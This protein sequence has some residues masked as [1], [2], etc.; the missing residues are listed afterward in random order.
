MVHEWRQQSGLSIR[1]PTVILIQN[2]GCL[3]SRDLLR[4]A[5]LYR[6]QIG[7]PLAE[8][9][10]VWSSGGVRFSSVR[11]VSF[12]FRFWEVSGSSTDCCDWDSSLFSQ[13][14]PV[15]MRMSR[16]TK[17][18]SR[19]LPLVYQFVFSLITAQSGVKRGVLK[20]RN[21]YLV[22]VTVLNLKLTV[23]K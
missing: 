8:L 2:Q 17:T 18:T 1:S 11:Y 22:H 15:N 21:W 4:S 3:V 10:Y 12:V 7:R 19:F 23:Y 13:V 14:H 16:E 20:K 9:A 6:E 5:R